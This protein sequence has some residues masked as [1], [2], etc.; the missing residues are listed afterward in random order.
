MDAGVFALNLNNEPSNSNN[1]ISFRCCKSESG[2][3][4]AVARRPAC[5][6]GLGVLTL[7]TSGFRLAKHMK[8]WGLAS[9]FGDRQPSP[10]EYAKDI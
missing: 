10:P 5:A 4:L 6:P 3:M 8:W 7:A 2:P 9:T 1:N